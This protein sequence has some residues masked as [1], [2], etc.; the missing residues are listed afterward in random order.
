MR[1][2][3]Q[4]FVTGY[5]NFTATVIIRGTWTTLIEQLQKTSDIEEVFQIHEEAL[6]SAMKGFFLLDAKSFDLLNAI[7]NACAQFA[8]ELKKWRKTVD[9]K[10]IT[11][12]LKIRHG[13]PM[14]TFYEV[15]EK[16]VEQLIQ[17]L[18]ALSNREANQIYAS[19]VRWIN[20]NDAYGHSPSLRARP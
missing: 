15:F 18:L 9:H 5:L 10:G 20:I 12:E 6:D 17:N 1:W 14:K 2:A 13:K 19:F 16:K 8:V 11:P 4:L 3:M 7:A